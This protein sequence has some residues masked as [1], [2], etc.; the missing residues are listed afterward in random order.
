MAGAIGALLAIRP[1]LGRRRPYL[2]LYLPDYTW[3]ALIC[4]GLA[5][6]W[7]CL[8]ARLMLRTGRLDV[9]MP[10]EDARS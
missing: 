4:G 9:S 5:F 3:T 8:R 2:W 6:V 10:R 7:G 1:L